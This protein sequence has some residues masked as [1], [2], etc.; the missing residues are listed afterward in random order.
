M[1]IRYNWEI[2][3]EHRLMILG[4]NSPTSKI[5]FSCPICVPTATQFW[6]LEVSGGL[7]NSKWTSKRM[8]TPIRCFKCFCL[9]SSMKYWQKKKSSV[10]G[11]SFTKIE[12]DSP[13]RPDTCL[14]CPQLKSAEQGWWH[15]TQG[16]ECQHPLSQGPTP[17]GCP[18]A[19]RPLLPRPAL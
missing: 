17:V 10:G 19:P 11:R 1:I 2:I 16:F 4:I 6:E 3:Q 5:S 8:L 18:P 14:V 15:R 9:Y 7:K 12:H 13:Q